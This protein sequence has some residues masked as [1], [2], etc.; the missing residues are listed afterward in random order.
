MDTDADN[1]KFL[2]SKQQEA[3][4]RVKAYK[5]QLATIA[6][7]SAGHNSIEYKKTLSLL[8]DN[9]SLVNLYTDCIL[10]LLDR[11]HEEEEVHPIQQWLSK[12]PHL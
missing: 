5:R 9:D 7:S 6:K 1:L 2:W 4:D 3:L 11:I 10:Q 12:E 8:Q